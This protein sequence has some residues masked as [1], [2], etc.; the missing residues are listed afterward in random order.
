MSLYASLDYGDDFL[1]VPDT[2][3]LSSLMDKYHML[4]LQTLSQGKGLSLLAYMTTVTTCK[5]A[6]ENPSVVH[7]VCIIQPSAGG[8]PNGTPIPSVVGPANSGKADIIESLSGMLGRQL[9][10]TA[11][12]STSQ[13]AALT[14]MVLGLSLSKSWGVFME[15]SDLTLQALSVLVEHVRLLQYR[16][17]EARERPTLR[18]FG[19]ATMAA[20]R[21]PWDKKLGGV[22]SPRF[23]RRGNGE[24]SG[25]DSATAGGGT[26][27]VFATVTVGHSHPLPDE[28]KACFREIHVR[29]YCYLPV[30]ALGVLEYLFFSFF[31]LSFLPGSHSGAVLLSSCATSFTCH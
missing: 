17:R 15:I 3:Y 2:L 21:N 9:V 18:Q 24:G 28:T 16:V 27:A 31:P 22:A 6:G 20:N 29:Y 23:K 7:F 11:C 1:G 13:P 12:T 10:R 30:L 5:L 19:L 26:F 25:D 4:L 8:G 14:R